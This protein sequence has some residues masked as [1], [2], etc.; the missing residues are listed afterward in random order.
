MVISRRKFLEGATGATA[1][2]LS[3][4]SGGGKVDSHARGEA[5]GRAGNSSCGV[6]DLGND[7]ALRESLLGYQAAL[8]EAGI[9]FEVLKKNSA[10][11]HAPSG[12][13][14]AH[15]I[16]I[17]P[18]VARLDA[19][20]AKGLSESLREGNTVLF[21]SAAA[22]L[23][24]GEF[25]AHREQI[26]SHFGVRLDAPMDLWASERNSPRVPYVD[27]TWPLPTKTRDFSRI[28]SLAAHESEVIGRVDSLPV[29]LKRKVGGGTLIFLGSALGPH[30][31][32]G[33]QEARAWLRALVAST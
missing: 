32:A 1:A 2:L 30:L 19:R 25:G 24:A 3:F 9:P 11:I 13:G 20:V 8:G 6:L 12:A 10:P 15:R 14:L 33:D 27:F 16:V 18:A 28:V 29:A 31:R 23:H 21:E 26:F 5:L 22:F 4:S 17:V 7:C